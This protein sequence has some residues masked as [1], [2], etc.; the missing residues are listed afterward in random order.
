MI[1]KTFCCFRKYS[2]RR[3]RRRG[4][5]SSPPWSQHPHKFRSYK[6]YE[7]RDIIFWIC[8]ATSLDFL[9][10]RLCDL[11]SGSLSWQVTNLLFGGHWSSASWDVAYLICYVTWK[12]HRIQGSY[13]FMS[14]S[15]SL[16]VT[17]LPSLVDI[18]I[19]VVEVCFHFVTWTEDH[20][21]KGSYEIG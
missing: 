15:S 1:K 14:G 6:S 3:W 10:K 12:K 16:Y 11:M 5:C 18:G 8:Y 19:V 17:T 21:S 20:L 13:N 4:L 7:G 2:K 9:N